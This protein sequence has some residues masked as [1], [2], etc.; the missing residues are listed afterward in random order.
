MTP[1]DHDDIDGQNTP[2]RQNIEG[3]FLNLIMF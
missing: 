1:D 2:Q 3:T